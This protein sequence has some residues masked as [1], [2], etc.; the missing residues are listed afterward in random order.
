MENTKIS[1]HTE[2]LLQIMHLKGEKFRQ[3]EEL[4]HSLKE[5]AYSLSPAQIVKD[6]LHKLASD[7]EVRVDLGKVGLNMGANFIIE[8]VLGRSNSIKGFLSSIL[9]EKISG[10]II[11]NNSSKII[12]GISNLLFPKQ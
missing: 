8:K 11:N 4:K 9:V 1:G 7:K 12:S 6:S 10:S 5:F 2:L 3:E